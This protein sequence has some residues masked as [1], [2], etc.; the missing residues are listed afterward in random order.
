MQRAFCYL[1]RLVA[2]AASNVSTFSYYVMFRT[3][4][5]T[6][7]EHG[8]TSR[9]VTTCLSCGDLVRAWPAC[10]ARGHFM[11][12]SDAWVDTGKHAPRSHCRTIIGSACFAVRSYSFSRTHG[13]LLSTPDVHMLVL[14]TAVVEYCILQV[15]SSIST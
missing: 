5:C 3:V 14:L 9:Q 13:M 1:G 8:F 2:A 10:G 11:M 6:Q 4:C 12:A 7:L 15:M